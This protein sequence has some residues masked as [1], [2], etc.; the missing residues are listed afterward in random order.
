MLPSPV[1]PAYLA[2]V[3]VAGPVITSHCGRSTARNRPPHTSWWCSCSPWSG[4][5][6]RLQHYRGGRPAPVV[7]LASPNPRARGTPE[8]GLGVHQTDSTL[9]P[10]GTRRRPGGRLLRSL[11]PVL[12]G[13]LLLAPQATAQARVATFEEVLRGTK[14]QAGVGDQRFTGRLVRFDPDSLLS[15]CHARLTGAHPAWTQRRPV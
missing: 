4:P 13:V 7:P 5:S 12:C 9:C 11:L 8:S 14:V 6:C 3:L 15:P 10:F 2:L 1:V